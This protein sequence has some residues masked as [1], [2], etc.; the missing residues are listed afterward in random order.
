MRASA[1]ISQLFETYLALHPGRD[2]SSRVGKIQAHTEGA[3][4][5]IDYLVDNFHARPVAILGRRF[6]HYLGTHARP[7]AAVERH[8]QNHLDAQRID[9]RQ[10]QNGPCTLAGLRQFAGMLQYVQTRCR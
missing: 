1:M 6:G 8:R 4:G 10:L 9:L 7:D 3:A 5:R 2:F